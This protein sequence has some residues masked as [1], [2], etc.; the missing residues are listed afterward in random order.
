[1]NG[2]AALLVAALLVAA[3]LALLLFQIFRRLGGRSDGAERARQALE[4][5]SLRAGK[6]EAER[7]LAAEEQ[8]ASRIPGLEAERKALQ[9]RVEA[10]MLE[11]A[12]RDAEYA[13][14]A[15]TLAQERRQAE[16]KQ[17]LLLEAREKMS[18]EFKLLAEEV[19]SRHGESFSRQNREQIDG[20]LTPLRDRLAE[21]QQGLQLAHL[22]TLRDRTVLAEQIRNLTQSSA[23]MSD[24]TRN[25][26]RALKGESQVQGAW[27]EMILSTILEKSGLREGEEYVAQ[28]SH[29]AEDGTRLR[30]DVIVNLPGGEKIIIDS[31]VSLTA[32]QDLVSAPEAER[33]GAL[34][35]HLGSMRA[36]IREL[37]GKEYHAAV[38]RLDY[39]LMFVP[40]EGALAAAIQADPEL[41]SLAAEANVA[42]ATP[43]TLMIALRTVA[44]V[45]KVERRNE[46]AEAIAAR[47]GHLYD[48]FA[49]FV[50]DMGNISKYLGQTRAAY[51]E[52]MN[53]LTLGRGNLVA[54]AEQLKALGAKTSKALPAS[55][56]VEELPPGAE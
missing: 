37:G 18:R 8:K 56:A 25:L 10:L 35:R 11:Q 47:A 39:V 43:T 22:E 26:T 53:K 33:A 44:N 7:R 50:A 54:Q 13:R 55:L 36:H 31:K 14:L 6:G 49:G 17:A 41:T 29:T 45:W 38:G 51:D 15:E 4:L 40:I 3:G 27:G 30:P 16:E 32:F 19:M 5:E 9:G 52:A 24:E 21:F 42:I 34:Q 2:S 23:A 1:M 48:K 12:R 28:Q 20:L 46:H